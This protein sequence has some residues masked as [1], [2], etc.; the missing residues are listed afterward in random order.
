MGSTTTAATDG[1][2]GIVGV[3]VM[4]T[5]GEIADGPTVTYALAA[6]RIIDLGTVTLP[7]LPAPDMT[8]WADGGSD[9]P[10]LLLTY[11]RDLGIVIANL[12]AQIAALQ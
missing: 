2:T 8:A 6:E 10:S 12:E 1:I 11:E 5:T 3:D 7:A 4:S 9:T